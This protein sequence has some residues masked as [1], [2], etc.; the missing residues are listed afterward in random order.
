MQLNNL[1]QANGGIGRLRWGLPIRGGP[2]DR[3]SWTIEAFR[4]S[5]NHLAYPHLT[6]LIVDGMGYGCGTGGTLGAAKE[7]AARQVLRHLLAPNLVR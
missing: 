6:P 5:P 4:Q 2:D 1:L 7:E 3:P